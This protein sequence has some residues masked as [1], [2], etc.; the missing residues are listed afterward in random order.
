MHYL[1]LL[2]LSPLLSTLALELKE[3]WNTLSPDINVP[4]TDNSP[5]ASAGNAVE[6]L[7]VGL[8]KIV[9]LID[10]GIEDILGGGGIDHVLDHEPLDGLILWNKASAVHAVDSLLTAGVHLG[11]ATVPSL[12]RHV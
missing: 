11:T 7:L 9:I 4:D 1:F 8:W 10:G 2:V 12:L 5:V 6:G 3:Q